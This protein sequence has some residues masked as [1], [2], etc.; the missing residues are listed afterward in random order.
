MLDKLQNT[1]KRLEEI[2]ES[3]L[4]IE[5][6]N[7]QG[8]YRALM[9]EHKQ[10]TPIVEKYREYKRAKKEFEEAEQILD[11]GG[12]DKDFKEMAQ[13]QLSTAKNDIEQIEEELKI[14]LLPKDPDDDRNVIIEIRGGAG[15]DEAAL[16]ANSLFRMYSLYAQSKGWKTE[17]INA[18][19]TELG[20]YKEI[21]FLV[22]GDGA[23]A[24]LKYESGVHRVQ[25]VPETEAQGRIHTSTITVAVLP[26]MEEVDVEINP[27]ELEI[28]TYRS[29]GAGGQHINKTE[30][31]IRIIHHPSGTVVECQEE[32]S[33]IKNKEKAMKMLYSKLYE[34]KLN[35]Q[36]D[37]IAAERKIQVGTGDRSERIR[38]Y[39][40]PQSRVTDH[41]IALT[42]YK[43][44]AFMN[45]DCDEIFD[46]LAI[47]D[48]T[49]KLTNS[50][51]S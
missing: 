41:R 17:V 13:Q 47:A 14:M 15:G 16:F 1:E 45:G 32:R 19:P 31:A 24:K 23:Y 21:S 6:I 25:R 40:F 20:G 28:Q 11:E 38:T 42:L 30:S 50:D 49:A 27:A 12:L 46:A 33:Q 36:T 22:E 2:N 37:K 48:R 3:L 7:D 44:E 10:L 39:N 29:S 35:E 8:K 51:N 18:N 9:K 4:D 34:K 26:E 43:L 5:V